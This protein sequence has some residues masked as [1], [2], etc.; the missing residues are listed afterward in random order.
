M[1]SWPLASGNWEHPADVA[2]WE[3]G[4]QGTLYNWEGLWALRC[5]P[6]CLLY[7]FP[8]HIASPVWHR[9]WRNPAL[10]MSM[11]S[12]LHHRKDLQVGVPSHLPRA[13]LISQPGQKHRRPMG[14][15]SGR[16]GWSR[17]INY[18]TVTGGK[19]GR[20][21]PMRSGAFQLLPPSPRKTTE[22]GCGVVE[23]GSGA[24]SRL[25]STPAN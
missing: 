1:F 3:E 13:P 17:K 14:G 4:A 22:G 2:E 19:N 15:S 8:V 11:E 21:C 25:E 24:R 10:E 23:P 6:V 5:A 9:C 7:V 18:R 20:L 12:L 16:F